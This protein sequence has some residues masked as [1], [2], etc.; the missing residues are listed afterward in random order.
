MSPGEV[1]QV[2]LGYAAV[3]LGVLL[4]GIASIGLLR[5]RDAYSRLV[6]TTKSGT[7]G[8]CLVLLGVLILEPA[9]SHAVLLLGAVAL[10][11]MTSPV[12]GFAL[13]RAAF[14]SDAPMPAGMLYDELHAGVEAER[15]AASDRDAGD[16]TAGSNPVTPSSGDG[17]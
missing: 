1:V 8:V 2:V 15:L 6:A 13:G 3:G 10:Q 5:F 9:W 16:E 12:G 11:I 17:C 7:L 14:R 4:F